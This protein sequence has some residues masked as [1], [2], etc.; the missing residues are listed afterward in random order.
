MDG[1]LVFKRRLK[2]LEEDYHPICHYSKE[3]SQRT[4]ICRRVQGR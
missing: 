2:T 4:V 1:E 3:T